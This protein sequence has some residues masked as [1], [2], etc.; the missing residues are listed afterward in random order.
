[1]FNLRELLIDALCFEPRADCIQLSEFDSMS[2]V[3]LLE[4]FNYF[5]QS[6]VKDIKSLVKYVRCVYK[7]YINKSDLSESCKQ[8]IKVLNVPHMLPHVFYSFSIYAYNL[9]NKGE[10]IIEGN[11]AHIFG[12]TVNLFEY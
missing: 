7:T 10:F 12:C 11:K 9:K 5:N 2:N 1:M 3:G 6:N 8:L 4:V